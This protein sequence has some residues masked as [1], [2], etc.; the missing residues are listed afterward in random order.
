L[1]TLA[2]SRAIIARAE[3]GRRAVVVG[4]SF[5]GLEVAASLVARGVAVQ[6]V[7][8]ERRPLERVLGAE[9][10][11]LVR[12]V[13]EAHGVRF[14]LGRSLAAVEDSRVRLDDGTLLDAD[15]VVAG[16]GVRPRTELA[17][18]AGLAVDRGILVDEELRAA[19]GV[20]AA[21]DVARWPERRSGERVRIEHWVVAGR[22]G[23]A[24]ARSLLGHAPRRAAPFFWSAHY[25]LTIRYVGCAPSWDRVAVDG[26]LKGR[27]AAVRYF[28]EGKLLAVATIGRD[29]V[30]LEAARDFE[31]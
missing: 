27:D 8:H 2:D 19:P 7:G 4:A 25:D 24:V 6:V 5:I 31:A 15:L 28:R 13:H 14:H 16:V 1:R 11:D 17:E 30:A 29:R 22:Q 18:R 26:D 20:W 23:H 21:G 3:K 10:G 12:A 9:V